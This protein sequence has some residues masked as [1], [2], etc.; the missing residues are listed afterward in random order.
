MQTHFSPRQLADPALAEANS[1][2]RACVHCGFCT[3]T[4]PTYVLLGDELDSPRGRISLVKEMLEQD[5]P[6]T[7]AVA[8]HLDRC[9]SC[10]ACMSTCPSGVDYMHLID[11][12][13]AHVERTYRRPW[14]ERALRATVGA[15]LSH[16]GRLRIALALAWFARPFAGLLP[17]RLRNMLKLA[18]K[19]PGVTATGPGTYPAAGPRRMRVALLTGC[20]Q[21]VMEDSINAATVRLLTRHGVE[22]VV[23]KGAS[24]CGA[25]EHHLGRLDSAR[26][27]AVASIR[28]WCAEIDGKGLDA[29]VA[30]TSGC[31]TL[32]KDYGH[33]F[34]G[35]PALV[36]DATRVSELVKDISEILATL[37]LKFD[38][39][40]ALRVVY[41]SACSL[42]HGQRITAQ[43]VKL[44]TDAGFDVRQ[45]AESH[46]CCGS[47]GSYNI[48]QPEIAAALRDRKAANLAAVQPEV[49]C[50]GNVGC[51]VQIR[52]GAKVP[53]VHT[54]ELLDWATG[55][56]APEGLAAGR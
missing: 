49:I 12:G 18:P 21:S 53:V 29:I 5:K 24:C 46:L 35:D 26:A 6:A 48:L 56:P 30:N 45:P 7:A 10:F 27:A 31:G 40:Q 36:A 23:S 22:V 37:P 38:A 39:V 14:A 41:H 20:V 51:L 32:V 28:A 33:L 43:P 15:V 55:G 8:T 47:A 42:Q 50:A 44:L 19:R 13:R 11:T 52:S 4:C 1:I 3:A 9:L 25:L 2:L 16:P 17:A 34:R 54:V